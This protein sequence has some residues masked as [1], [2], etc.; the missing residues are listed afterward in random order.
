MCTIQKYRA[1]CIKS[2]VGLTWHFKPFIPYP[3]YNKKPLLSSYQQLPQKYTYTQFLRAVFHPGFIKMGL[4]EFCFSWMVDPLFLNGNSMPSCEV[5]VP[6]KV[7]V[8]SALCSGDVFSLVLEATRG[9]EEPSTK[10]FH[11]SRSSHC[12][13]SRQLSENTEPCLQFLICACS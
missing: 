12:L 1:F 4:E 13:N 10:N 6:W 8:I 5:N 9:P 3:V 11:W 7:I 2:K